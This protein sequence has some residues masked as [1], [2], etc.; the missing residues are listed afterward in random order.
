MIISWLRGLF[1]FLFARELWIALAVLLLAVLIW[2][3]GPLLALGTWHP[4]TAGWARGGAIGLLIMALLWRW[5]WRFGGGS[6][7]RLLEQLRRRREAASVPPPV[8]QATELRQRFQQALWTLRDAR[9]GS[10]RWTHW[11]DRLSG[12]YVYRLPWY[13]V[14]GDTGSGKTALLHQLHGGA[15]SLEFAGAGGGE[16]HTAQLEWHLGDSA[17]L[18]DTP[19]RF[20]EAAT[21]AGSDRAEFHQL[22]RHFRPRQPLNGVVLVSDVSRLPG[23]TSDER[24]AHGRRLRTHLLELQQGLDIRLPVY[25][26]LSHVDRLSG[27]Q[28]YFHE[29][30]PQGR[31]QIW[32]FTGNASE[33]PARQGLETIFLREFKALVDRLGDGL[34]DVLASEPE[35]VDRAE[36]WLFPQ[37]FAQLEQPLLEW[38]TA[39]SRASRFEPELWLRGVYFTSTGRGGAVIEQVLAPIRR[40]LQ[41]APQTAEAVPEGRQSYFSARLLDQL[42]VPEAGLAG[43]NR[44]LLWRRRLLHGASLGLLATVVLVLLAVWIDSYR[45]NRDYLAEVGRHASEYQAQ[46][47]SHISLPAGDIEALAPLLDPL[48]QLPLSRRFDTAHP[49]FYSYRAGLYQG[50]KIQI[51]TDLVYRRALEEKLLPQAASRIQHLLAS[52]P[53][54]DLEYTYNALKAYLMLY[55]SGHYEAD[56]LS[57]WLLLDVEK[58][59]PELTTRR[60]REALEGHV[61]QLFQPHPVTSPFPFD[62]DLVRSAR[63]RLARYSLP[64][65]AYHQMQRRLLGSMRGDQVSVE[66]VAGPQA[67]MALVRKSGQPLS[68][69]IAPLYT[70]QG[71]WDVFSPQVGHAALDMEK[72][73]VWVLGSRQAPVL[74]D[75]D[76]SRLTREIKRLYFNDYIRVWD[77]YL[78]DLSVIETRSVNQSMQLARILSAT[79]SPLKRFMLVA[80]RET[81]LLHD[82]QSQPSHSLLGR[83]QARIGE[84]KQSLTDIFGNQ[85]V[86]AS[87]AETEDRIESMVDNH[88]EPLHRMVDGSG[89]DGQ[90]PSP[91]DTSLQVVDELYNYLTA[92]DA[93]LGSGNPPP[94]S[95]VFN[96]LQAEAGRMPMPFRQIMGDLAIRGSAQVTGAVQHSIDEDAAA[97]IGRLCRQTIADRYPFVRGI[98]RDVA[99]DDFSR[100]FAPNGLMDAFYQKNLAARVDMNTR[101]WT[102]RPSASGVRHGNPHLLEAFQNAET[103]RNVFF[104]AG[105]NRPSLKFDVTP[106]DLDASI[107]QFTLDVDGQVLRYA[108]GPQMSRT[109]SW[110][111]QGGS[112]QVRLELTPASASGILQT[113]GPWALQRLFDAA[114]LTP[115]SAPESF[116]ATFH[117]GAR[118]LVLKITAD[119]AFNPFRLP[120]MAAFSCPE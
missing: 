5:S 21:A 88:F 61:A 107:N 42:M 10:R 97:S 118:R 80:A 39:L 13:L 14:V 22:L 15:P 38:L 18:V 1:S 70:Y 25:L 46:A 51:A 108:H 113:Q 63:E 36:A 53:A 24:K 67:S 73:D 64:Q 23:M 50:H 83:A 43:I 62:A 11:L 3:Y 79:D 78:G 101:R 77:A 19:G 55:Q 20:I 96:K 85:V 4:L 26:V 81:T 33:T 109:M 115:G 94:P 116:T 82:R 111:V 41:L 17:V 56:F 93:A 86:P 31:E 45:H 68:E 44:R 114:E 6:G 110:P 84:V 91:L 104:A 52:A 37:E 32:G 49:P 28:A 92:T 100:M 74:D 65:R 119:S 27:F 12:Q 57:A 66:S 120:Q 9:A 76:R 40:V 60:Q 105:G 8:A 89:S 69:G 58:S 16:A 71:Y 103:I 54:D 112:H 75:L 29:L 72:E 47:G 102:F 30:G 117:L 95:D 2:G 90:G 7:R 48:L 98:S 59:M 106:L 35:L 99:I 34:I 87:R